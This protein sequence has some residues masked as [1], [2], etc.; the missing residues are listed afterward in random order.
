M[1]SERV[2]AL[3]ISTKTGWASAV[4]SLDKMVLEDYGTLE[5]IHEPEGPYPSNYVLWAY[6]CFA[7]ILALIEKFKPNVLVIEETSKG[8]KN[9]LSQKVLEWEHFLLAQYI[10]GRE[11]LKTV[12][13]LTEQWRREIGC[14]MNDAEKIK[15]KTVRD[16]KKA[17][18]KKYGK[19]TTVAHDIDGKRI[20]ITGRKHINVRRANE[21]FGDQLKAPLLRKDED[22]ADSLGLLACYYFR[23]LKDN[24]AEEVS[25][26]DIVGDRL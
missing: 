13:L 19:K 10:R 14:K 2:L 15:N 5:Q 22:T 4:V 6:D 18:L 16:Y 11:N 9:A 17:Y 21:I 23:Q 12:Y 8:S 24:K 3:D 7:E 1:K 26:E 25:I 20:G